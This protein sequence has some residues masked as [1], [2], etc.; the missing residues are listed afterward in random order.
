MSNDAIEEMQAFHWMMEMVQ[1]VDVGIV[2]LDR[3]FCIQVWN[4][5]MES[6]SGLLAN[7]VRDK[8]L[9]G[10]FPEIDKNWFEK[11]ARPVFEL[12]TRAFMTWELRPF[13]FKFPNYRPI[14]GG[15]PFMY[16]NI[17]LAPLR[18]ANGQVNSISMMIYDMTDVAL[19]KRRFEAL[20]VQINESNETS[21]N[22]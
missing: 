9:F 11:K 13:L 19:G 14:T 18:S 7:S 20:Q 15:D 6:H 1:S 22:S 4:D 21:K 8:S 3:N 16:Q 17:T 12:H 10:L 5:F 2:V